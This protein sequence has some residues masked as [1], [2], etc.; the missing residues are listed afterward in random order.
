MT[1]NRCYFSLV[2]EWG[3]TIIAQGKST[4]VDAALGKRLPNEEPES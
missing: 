3:Q 4:Y 2:P 1:K